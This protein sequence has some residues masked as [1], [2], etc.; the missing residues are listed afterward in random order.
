M[1]NLLKLVPVLFL[2]AAT[3]VACNKD[4]APTIKPKLTS[5]SYKPN[6]ITGKPAVAFKSSEIKL[7][8]TTAEA[9]FTIK[10]ITKDGKKFTN[11]NNGKGFKIDSKGKVYADKDHT[12]VKGTYVVTVSAKDKSD[13]KTIKTTTIKVAIT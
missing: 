4:D 8:P 6:S 3:L 10:E 2:F 12:L 9:T 13:N 1:K 11:P 7:A 5:V